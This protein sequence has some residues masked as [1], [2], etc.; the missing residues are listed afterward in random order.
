M[1]LDYLTKIYICKSSSDLNKLESTYVRKLSCKF[2]MT[3]SGWVV[4]KEKIFQWPHLIFVITSP[5][6]RSWSFIC[7]ILKSFYQRMICTMSKFD[8]NWPAASG[9]DL[10]SCNYSFFIM[11][12]PEP[13]GSWFEEILIYIMSASFHVNMTFSSSVVHEKKIFKWPPPHICDYLPSEEELVLYLN[14]SES[15]L[16]KD[17]LYQ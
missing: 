14:N 4:F 15:H 3:Y 9:E 1:S 2:N 6:K 13:W 8:W 16:P 10:F 11:A 5:L 12:P 7:T 17:N